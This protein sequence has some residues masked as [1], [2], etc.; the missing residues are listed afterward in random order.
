MLEIDQLLPEVCTLVSQRFGLYYVGIFLIEESTSREK[1]SFAVLKAGNGNAGRQMLLEGH[2]LAVGGDSMIGWATANHKPRIAQNVGQEVVRFNNPHLPL[3]RSE[4][5]LPI[6]VYEGRTDANTQG[7]E[8][9]GEHILGA[10]TIQSCEEAA[11]DQDD[12]LIL[13]GIADSLA[14]AIENSRLFAATE[15][16]LEE[17]RTLHRQYLEQ[18][19]QK[20][21]TLH[22]EI[23]YSFNS[24][25]LSLKQSPSNSILEIPIRLRDQI[26]GSLMLEPGDESDLIDGENHAW[27]SD[28]L[29]L[30][31]TV[32]NQAALALENARLLEETRRKVNL[33]HTATDI[34]SKMWASANIDAILRTA[35]QEL[36]HTL[37]AREGWIELWPG[38]NNSQPAE[39]LDNAITSTNGHKE[40]LDT[41]GRENHG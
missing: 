23:N 40:K 19:W 37:G 41:Q 18:A 27:S 33:E 10:M 36:S 30:I 22:G 38:E 24:G 32:T 39:I 11:F 5:A 9:Q 2:K 16:R 8:S 7:H 21:T 4:L 31:E 35:L 26:I 28:D 6:L 1:E 29:M 12:I 3:T 14:S 20:E 25:D 17:I 15:A 13:Q 34:A